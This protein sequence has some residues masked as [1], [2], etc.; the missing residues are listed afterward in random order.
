MAGGWAINSG[1]ACLMQSVATLWDYVWLLTW[2]TE[3]E[4]QRFEADRTF[5]VVVED[6]VTRNDG[7]GRHV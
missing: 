6:A 7:D 5:V 1:E 3:A 4:A 2:K